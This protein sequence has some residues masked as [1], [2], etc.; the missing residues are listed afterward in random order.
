[1]LKFFCWVRGLQL[2]SALFLFRNAWLLRVKSS[3]IIHAPFHVSLNAVIIHSFDLDTNFNQSWARLEDKV[4][5]KFTLLC[6]RVKW[7]KE[8]V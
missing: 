3:F 4:K 1:M 6:E 8:L 7:F 5:T 2:A